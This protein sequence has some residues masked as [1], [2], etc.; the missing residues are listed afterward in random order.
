[1]DHE[2]GMTIHCRCTRWDYLRG[3]DRAIGAQAAAL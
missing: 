1:M 2:R 3:S